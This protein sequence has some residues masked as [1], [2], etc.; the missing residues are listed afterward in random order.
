LAGFAQGADEGRQQYKDDWKDQYAMSELQR[1]QKERAEQDKAFD[2]FL[3]NPAI[4]FEIKN[5]SRMNRG[6]AMKY[7]AELQHKPTEAP[8]TR[9]VRI[10][11][12][13]VTQEWDNGKWK[14]VGRGSA[15]KTTADTVVN[16]GGAKFDEHLG[17]GIADVY[18]KQVDQASVAVQTKGAASQLRLLLHERG[19][20]LDGLSTI[21]S[22]FGLAPEGANDVVAAQAIVS[23]LIP[24][25]RVP[26]SGTTSDYDAKQFAASLPRVWN[27]PGA[28]ELIID[29]MEAYADY[30][31][32][33]GDIITEVGASDSQNKA[34]E[35]RARLAQ[36][37]DPFALWKQNIQ[38][39]GTTGTPQKSNANDLIKKY[40]L[41]PKR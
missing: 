39:M 36:L 7:W 37:P 27:Q 25:Q 30:Q 28:N 10:G 29:T 38:K 2:E 6:E 4:P 32:A 26:G 24:K 41:T 34:A 17:K 8:K 1:E 21:A 9:E 18:A 12:E 3:A 16:V 33:V 40:G 19:G 11:N 23:G 14:E 20:A 35:I 31:I 5:W 13:Q 22:G 15:F